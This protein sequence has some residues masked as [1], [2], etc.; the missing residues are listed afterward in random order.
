MNLVVLY[1]LLVKATLT[2]FSGLASLP[3]IR[4]DFVLRYHMLTDRQLNTAVAAGR[5]GPGPV[6]IYVVSIGYL[7][8]GVPGA[9][10]GWLAMITPAFLIIPML[11]FL[12]KR[13]EHRRARAVTR[14]VLCAGAG[15][16]G[17][18]AIPLARDVIHGP[19][20]LTIVAASF[21]L[22]AFTRVD[23]LWVMLGA[24]LVG[25]AAFQL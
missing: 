14:S 7:A 19:L 4:G 5:I 18:A 22:I 23:S 13:A 16:M 3:V 9:C 12:G 24:A 15:L 21:A 6:G 1:L 10:A 17:S 8:G 2:S 11:R 25:F 20:P